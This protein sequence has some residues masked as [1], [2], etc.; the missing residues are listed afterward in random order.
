MQTAAGPGTLGAMEPRRVVVV[1]FPE[2]QILDAVGPLEVFQRAIGIEARR[3]PT[4]PP[5]YRT[6]LVAA[7]AG[8]LPTSAGVALLAG[9][10]LRD[11]R[12]PID[13]LLV[14]GGQGTR[15]ALSDARILRF[16][17][18]VAPR[19]RR[20][21]SVCTGAFL[22]AEAGLLD[23]RRATTHWISA[24]RFATRYPGVHLDPDPIYVRDG[25][26]WTSAG[27]TAGMDLALALV[28]EDLGR[29]VALQA[30]REL[31]LFLRRP[32]GQSQ[33]SAQLAAQIS[34]REALRELQA[35]IIEHPAQDCSVEALAARVAL[36]PRHFARVFSREVGVTPARW[37]ERARVEAARRQLEDSDQPVEAVAAACGFGSA[38][39]LRRAFLRALRVNP[40]D[41]R[42]RFRSARAGVR[43]SGRTRRPPRIAAGR[44]G[45]RR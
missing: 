23:G 33:F 20:I 32:G 24:D 14:A 38:E 31:V 28:E 12:G 19:A 7:E 34:E 44:R 43:E 13:T 45:G 18:R 2:V 30:A 17:G 11:V 40:A 37:V 9:R 22:L 1:A 3:A 39:T 36:S 10:A 16:L 8:P 26:V 25:D 29:E 35:Q 27:V 4:S 6:E 15:E 21:A 5:P 41:Y 42:A